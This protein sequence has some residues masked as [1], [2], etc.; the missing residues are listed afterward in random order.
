[1][2]SVVFPAT[3]HTQSGNGRFLAYNP[4]W[5]KNLPRLNTSRC[6]EVLYYRPQST[7][8]VATPAFWPTFH[9]DGTISTGREGGRC[10]PTPFHYIQYTITYTVYAP[11]ERAD[12]SPHWLN[13][14]WDLQSLFGSGV[15]SCTLFIGW[16][17]ATPPLLPYLGLYEGAIGQWSDKIDDISL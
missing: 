3:E 10:T 7:H 16:D 14:E 13:M 4:S 12:T 11:A 8:R 17:P 1:M 2:Y 6:N 9:H 15:Y 5:W